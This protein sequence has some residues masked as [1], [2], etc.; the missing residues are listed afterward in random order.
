MKYKIIIILL[1]LVTSIIL[2][3]FTINKTNC[4]NIEKNRDYLK[5]IDISDNTQMI[6]WTMPLRE[7]NKETKVLSLDGTSYVVPI[8]TTWDE[9]Y[10]S[11]GKD[12]TK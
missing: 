2:F 7:H 3:Y 6:T 9:L 8:N 12:F 5:I 10:K 4:K 11:L 1:I